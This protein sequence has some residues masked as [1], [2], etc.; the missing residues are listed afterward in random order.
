MRLGSAVKLRDNVYQSDSINSPFVFGV[1]FPKIYVP[2]S[3]DGKELEAVVMHEKAH[4]E[5]CD[6]IVKPAA[7]FILAL[8]WFNPLVWVAYVLFCRD[9]ELACDERVI[10][11]LDDNGKADYS[12]ALLSCTSGHR[13][14]TSSPLAFGEVGVKARVKSVLGYRKPALW[15]IVCAVVVVVI[16]A[17]LFMTDPIVIDISD[18]NWQFSHVKHDDEYVYA[19]HERAHLYGIKEYK[20]IRVSVDGNKLYFAEPEL[21]DYRTFDLELENRTPYYTLYTMKNSSFDGY[22]VVSDLK[23]DA[24][25]S[26]GMMIIGSGEVSFGVPTNEITLIITDG[27]TEIYFYHDKKAPKYDPFSAETMPVTTT[28]IAEHISDEKLSFYELSEQSNRM[29]D[30]VKN[31]RKDKHDPGLVEWAEKIE[32]VWCDNGQNYVTVTVRDFTEN[33]LLRFAKAFA[34]C[35]YV[36]EQIN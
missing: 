16:A 29:W 26:G 19:S 24:D 10:R 9:V 35:S 27:I 25:M 6:H 11:T 4:I 33:N 32:S 2:F 1:P 36:I 13:I 3:L 21:N 8:H 34:E 30:Y 5:R 23:S 18:Y 7:F 22:A 20:D 15:V 28:V 12:Q 17:V 14:I 31:G